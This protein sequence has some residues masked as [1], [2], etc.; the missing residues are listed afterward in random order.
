[1]K[2]CLEPKFWIIIRNYIDK[3]ALRAQLKVNRNLQKNTEEHLIPYT[4]KYEIYNNQKLFQEMTLRRGF[5]SV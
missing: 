4:K 1:M 2:K 5:I 3:D